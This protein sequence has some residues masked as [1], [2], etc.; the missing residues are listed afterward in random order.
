MAY[1]KSPVGLAFQRFFGE[2][3]L[4]ADLSVSVDELG[5]LL[6]HSGPL[7]AAEQRAARIFGADHTFFVTNGT[8]TANKIVWHALVSRGDLVLVDRNCHKS[9]VHA[10][11]M[12]GAIPLYLEPARNALGIIGPIPLEEFS[13]AA[14]AAKIA[15]CPRAAGRA[16]RVRLVLL[17]HSTYDG[18]CYSLEPICRALGQQAEVLHVDE[19]WFAYAAFLRFMPVVSPWA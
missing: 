5:S 1:R 7:A 3:T 2:N 14:I 12:T 10:L 15:A 19:A 18:L 4:R 11:M 16:P 17:T 6:E 9:V 13:E 8:S